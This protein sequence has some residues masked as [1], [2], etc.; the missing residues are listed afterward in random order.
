MNSRKPTFRQLAVVTLFVAASLGFFLF[1]WKSFGG[2]SPFE[3]KP[4]RVAVSFPES[5]QL[6]PGA[7]V[8]IAGISVGRVGDLKSNKSSGQS[9][10][11]LEIDSRFAP[12]PTTT[13]ATLRAK[14][15][16]GETFVELVPGAERAKYLSDGGSIPPAQVAPTVELDELLRTM[17]AETRSDLRD[18]IQSSAQGFNNRG[19]DLSVALGSLGPMLQNNQKLVKILRQNSSQVSTLVR[20]SGTV[21]GA[22]TARSGQP[23][24]LVS[25]ASRVLN[26]TGMQQQQLKEFLNAFPDFQRN[27]KQTV[28]SLS[29]LADVATPVVSGL[30]PAASDLAAVSANLKQVSPLLQKTFAST[31]NVI[32]ASKQGLPASAKL[33]HDL[34]PLLVSLDSMLSELNPAHRFINQYLPEMRGAILN[35]PAA[36]ANQYVTESGQTANFLRAASPFGVES[37]NIWTRRS[38]AS[39]VAMYQQPGAFN[40]VPWQM[41]QFETRHCDGTNQKLPISGEGA[42]LLERLA[43]KI[44]R[45][46]PCNPR[47]QQYKAAD[48]RLLDYPQIS[49]DPPAPKR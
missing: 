36:I 18:W 40:T 14:T 9:D 8:R 33:I 39:R 42:K 1:L 4:Y 32:D 6:V 11:E 15:L 24:Q 44:D 21:A 22:L 27:A 10:A 29:T 16:L 47:Q 34:D 25:S 2:S 37:V 49:A 23:R 19:F 43:P 7:D 30:T 28:A 41:P 31:S 5:A 12:L 46:L 38:P 45:T 17:T 35:T 20:S 3:A 26:A 13:K 48:G